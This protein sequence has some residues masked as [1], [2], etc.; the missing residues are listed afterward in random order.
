MWQDM[1]L[2]WAWRGKTKDITP[3]P[4]KKRLDYVTLRKGS[5]C[6]MNLC[7]GV[8]DDEK[9]TPLHREELERL[10]KKYDEVV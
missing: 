8:W 10:C 2:Y 3:V 9:Y 5:I 7:I 4:T 6:E 1:K